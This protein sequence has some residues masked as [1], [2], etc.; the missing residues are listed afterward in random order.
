MSRMDTIEC[1]S[2]QIVSNQIVSCEN[3]NPHKRSILVLIV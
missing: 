2:N 1:V 3:T